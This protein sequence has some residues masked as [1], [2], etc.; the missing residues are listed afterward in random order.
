MVSI[1]ITLILSQEIE[2]TLFITILLQLFPFPF[3]LFLLF[4]LLHI[5][6]IRMFDIGPFIL[7]F[8]LEEFE[9]LVQEM[10]PLSL[11]FALIPGDHGTSRSATHLG[12]QVRTLKAFFDLKLLAQPGRVSGRQ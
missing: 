10:F 6:L 3:L 2:V 11:L 5:H 9:F 12:F 1:V 7:F 8:F 4:Q